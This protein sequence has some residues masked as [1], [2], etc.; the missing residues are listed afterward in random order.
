MRRTAFIAVF[1][2]ILAM[3]MPS[4]AQTGFGY[5]TPPDTTSTGTDPVGSI[6]GSFA[7][8]P[9]GA[10][11]YTIPIECPQGLPGMTPQVAITYNSQAGNGVA[12]YGCSISGIS[13]IT[14][15]PRD[16]FH[17]GVAAGISYTPDDAFSL[18]GRR[19][20][21][22][23]A[24]AGSDSAVYCLENDPKTRIVYHGLA[25][26]SQASQW[27]SVERPD[28]IRVEYGRGM[29]GTQSIYPNK[30][31]SWSVSSVISPA[32]SC[33]EYAYDYY[34][35]IVHPATI[36]YG[37]DNSIRINFEY[38]NRLDTLWLSFPRATGI[39]T[40]RLKTVTTAIRNN[41]EWHNYRRYSLTYNHT[42]DGANLKFSRLMSVTENNG[43]SETLRPVNFSWNYLPAFSVSAS[44]QDVQSLGLAETAERRNVSYLALDLNGDGLSDVVKC[45]KV[46]VSTVNSS[47]AWDTYITLFSTSLDSQDNIQFSRN[48]WG[49][50]SGL[51]S[52]I[53]GW[54]DM[55]T[56]PSPIDADG[57][58]IS[59]FLIPRYFQ[60]FDELRRVD[61]QIF[62]LNQGNTVYAGIS[63]ELQLDDFDD[64]FLYTVADLNNDGKD[65]IVVIEDHLDGTVYHGAIL[66]AS[67]A[68]NPI[69]KNLRFELQGKPKQIVPADFN[70][71]GLTDIMVFYASGYGLYVNDGTWL[72]NPNVTLTLATDAYPSGYAITKAYLGDFNGDG[73]PDILF[74]SD[75]AK[76]WY[77]RMGRGKADYGLILAQHFTIDGDATDMDEHVSCM[78]YDMDGDGRSDAVITKTVGGLTHTYWMKSNG[79]TLVQARHITSTNTDDAFTCQRTIGD[80]NGDGLAE[81]ASYGYNAYTGSNVTNPAFFIYRH[82]G[83]SAS[84]GKVSRV[85]DGMGNYTSLVYK[86]LTDTGTYTRGTGAA[87]PVAD[88]TPPLPV[89]Y[90]T[91]QNDGAS[92]DKTIA[93]HY[94]GMKTHRAG[95]GLMGFKSLTSSC[96][97]TGTS[98]TTE[99]EWNNTAYSP[100][101]TTQ[102]KTTGNETT[103]DESQIQ[104]VRYY[105]TL[106]GDSINAYY[107]LPKLDKHTDA[108][109]YHT[110]LTRWFLPDFQNALGTEET[111]FPDGHR[112]V[113]EYGDYVLRHSQWLPNIVVHSQLYYQ[114]DLGL[115]YYE[116]EWYDNTI[117]LQ[118]DTYGRVTSKTEHYETPL[119]VTT[120]YT[121][122]SYGNVL[123]KAT[124]A[125]GVESIT[126]EYQYDNTHRFV[127]K[128]TER[129]Y[130]VKEYERDLWGNVLTE[131]DKTRT[132]YPRTTSY[133][134]DSWGNLASV[135]SPDSQLTTYKRGWGRLKSKKYYVLEQA[136]GRP[137]VKTWYDSRGREVLTE[138]ISQSELSCKTTTSYN[139]KGQIYRI[140][141]SLGSQTATEN[142]TY[143]TNGRKHTD[144]FSTGE[145]TSYTYNWQ[146]VTTTSNGRS[147]TTKYDSWGN[148]IESTDALGNATTY[149]Y[150]SCGKPS[151]VT[152]CGATVTMEYDEAGNQT[153]LTDPDAGT[154]TYTYDAYG[155]IKT[156][157][158]GRN[159]TTSNT[160]DSKG[161]LSSSSTAGTA[162][163]Y[164]YGQ[165]PTD[166]GLL[167]STTRSGNTVSY[168][169]DTLGRVSQEARTVSGLGTR[170]F[171][172][173]YGSNGQLSAVQYP[174]TVSVGYQ[175]DSYGNRSAMTVGGTTVWQL[176][177]VAAQ[178]S[179]ITTTAQL[180][181]SL[182]TTQVADLDGRVTGKS[183]QDLYD[184]PIRSMTFT[185]NAA[186][187]NMTGRTGMF[188][189]SES[190]S[191]DY[192]DRLT[193]IQYGNGSSLDISY[194]PNGNITMQTDIGRYYYEGSKPHA[195]TAV[196]NTRH[197]IPTSQL[198]TQY[199][200][201]GKV[202]QIRDYG[203]NNYKML[204]DYGPDNE[205]WRTR[206][207][208]NTSTLQRTTYYMGDYEEIIEGGTTRR[209]YYLGG[210]VLYKKQTSCPDSIFYLFTDHLGSLITI[211]D[212]NGSE[213]FH[214]T[215]D[216][217]G[218]QTV[219]RNDIGFHRG[220]TGH[221]M[222]QEFGLINMN[223]RLYDPQIG[224]FLSTD[225]Y[226]QEPWDSQNFNRYSY[227]L[228]N[229]LKYSDPSGELAWFVPV[230]IGAAVGAYTGASIQSHNAAFWNWK[231]DAW[232]GAIAG[233]I[234]GA[235][236]GFN[237]SSALYAANP[238][239]ISGFAVGYPELT[240]AA[241]ITNSILQ[242]GV[243]NIG[244][245]AISNGGWDGAWKSG[246]VGLATGAWSVTGGFG[247]AN[248]FG[249]TSKLG[250]LAGKLGYQMIGT[251]SMSIGNN[252]AKNQ[253]LFSNLTLGIGPVNLTIGKGQRLL[254]WENNIGNIISNSFGL[255]NTAFGG[256]AQFDGDN[257]T[258]VYKGG[259]RDKFFTTETE[260]D[261][262]F[263]SYA[264]FGWEN[265]KDET[266][267]HE[268]HHLWQSRAMNNLFWP[269]YSAL[270]LSAVLAGGHFI[271]DFN[272]YE[273]IG[274][275]HY[276]YR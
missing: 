92:S 225:N 168:T 47:E 214:A 139:S 143:Y 88:I 3:A 93:Y 73:T 174:G 120:G 21:L 197:R 41:N 154:M 201:F 233:G 57:D 190:F 99:V 23:Q 50:Y 153:K 101:K 109:G 1:A 220:Y 34:N 238:T 256:K 78:V 198:Q 132:A 133:T 243:I 69:K 158:D 182:K 97:A 265:I 72:N 83:Y 275:L 173:T 24:A 237:V 180:G 119:A 222:L 121:Y 135:I 106:T 27:F 90:Q 267:T 5:V 2:V 85:T 231:S 241:G 105:N 137:W 151:S 162:T 9:L 71:D 79:T 221:E 4:Q 254:Q 39:M 239:N 134:Y 100:S 35:G 175:Y 43:S 244:I 226:V 177:D 223:G 94:G 150:A 103:V 136:T 159:Y 271:N 167:L 8:S 246:V 130:I 64:S 253:K 32:G 155:R 152:S 202:S 165:N 255:I 15:V 128:S 229:P 216:A 74:C 91:M 54:N 56:S 146:S 11:T 16:I 18:D 10:A 148:V 192:L 199:N 235:A 212:Q 268:M 188:S 161:R 206:L 37:I 195:V 232:K 194:A 176:T 51:Q 111:V 13:V 160:Y 65:E 245:N 186:T 240:K 129:G 102:T 187:G 113:T 126:V 261:T 249:A 104:S 76:N 191:Y 40:K 107:H 6:N 149:S 80:F 142:L 208:R 169:Y 147:T 45:S 200:V 263:G 26:Q 19:L 251:T 204:F 123:S 55:R 166:M 22:T 185:Y 84:H 66:Q 210:D 96:S 252:W 228:N 272:Y 33:N 242:N 260:K 156:Q 144:V 48:Q 67:P 117:K 114:S 205:R 207:Y 17:D 163:T 60:S 46:H 157:K 196:D 98:S 53:D 248:G 131:T 68:V 59:E 112:S 178:N 145:S 189:S 230:I 116:Q 276:W 38:E 28:G 7:V 125:Q 70:G 181:S 273:Q 193:G 183:L 20:I 52:S 108:Y 264:I 236:I 127:I 217:W 110:V 122:D 250:K 42:G 14:R 95:R 36:Y 81:L 219:S 262:A 75:N 209:L 224:R 227:C 257:L 12:G 266:Y 86:P 118:Y 213:K 44:S 171:Q 61:F 179:A 31:L 258:F 29:I 259:L 172:Y 62:K 141:R 218:N 25:S 30:V 203:E 124:S 82:T 138:S 234:I 115:P 87:Y 274:W 170:T 77:L 140:T 49:C 247:M 164:T 269:T 211:V 63:Y 58:G 89:V 215:Y 184:I 270:G